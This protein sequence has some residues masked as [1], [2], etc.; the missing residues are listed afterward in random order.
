MMVR[1]GNLVR[2]PRPDLTDARKPTGVRSAAISVTRAV[3]PG[4]AAAATVV[5]PWSTSLRSGG[6]VAE[7]FL[8]QCGV[9]SYGDHA[10]CA[11]RGNP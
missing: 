9:Q 5:W 7:V 10:R 11:R 1:L 2:T 6:K 4:G 8:E 3:S